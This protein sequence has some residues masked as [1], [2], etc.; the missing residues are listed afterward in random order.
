MFSKNRH[1][2][3]FLQKSYTY[4]EFWD[5]RQFVSTFF[6]QGQQLFPCPCVY[7]KP[8]PYL[9]PRKGKNPLLIFKGQGRGPCEAGPRNSAPRRGPCEAGPRNSAPSRGPCEAGPRNTAPRRGPCEAGTRNTAPRRG[10]CEAD[11]KEIRSDTRNKYE[12]P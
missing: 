12:C 5:V 9:A 1:C 3:P 2:W 10:P 11:F 6:P 4:K 7:K 8:C